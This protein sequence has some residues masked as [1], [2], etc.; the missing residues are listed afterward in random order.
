VDAHGL[1]LTTGHWQRTEASKG[2]LAGHAN[3]NQAR[4]RKR[5]A[6]DRVV[7]RPPQR[8]SLPL[9]S[10]QLPV[11]ELL[12]SESSD[13]ER[14]QPHPYIRSETLAART[15]RAGRPL[16]RAN[17]LDRQPLGRDLF[18]CVFTRDVC[19]RRVH[20]KG[21]RYTRYLDDQEDV[22]LNGPL[23]LP[24]SVPAQPRRRPHST[25]HRAIGA[26][27]NRKTNGSIIQSP[28]H[29]IPTLSPPGSS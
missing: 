17:L 10:Q 18:F 26:S 23:T 28:D 3:E 20:G 16:C 8:L 29:S 1:Q 25:V 6:S 5:Y 22:R 9:P 19:V 7:G 11:R 27:R 15:R 13:S 21:E 4:R 2:H 12:G 14:W 24:G